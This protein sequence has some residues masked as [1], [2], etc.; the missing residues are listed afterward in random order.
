MAIGYGRKAQFEED[1]EVGG[2]G[3]RDEMPELSLLE[4][5]LTVMSLYLKSYWVLGRIRSS[6]WSAETSAV[7][8]EISEKAARNRS[9]S[10]SRL[11]ALV[12]IYKTSGMTVDYLLQRAYRWYCVAGCNKFVMMVVDQRLALAVQLSDLW[13]FKYSVTSLKKDQI[14]ADQW[15]AHFHA[16]EGRG[17]MM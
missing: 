14:T 8:R 2:G 10:P 15:E 5:L 12:F 9:R 11:S 16:L 6:V 13:K 17:V 1:I 7:N 4:M 3:I